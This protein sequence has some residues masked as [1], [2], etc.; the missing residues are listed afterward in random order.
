MVRNLDKEYK[1]VNTIYEQQKE[2]RTTPEGKIALRRAK[3]RQTLKQMRIIKKSHGGGLLPK[4][5][6]CT[7]KK[8]ERLVVNYDT[9]LCYNCKY[10]REEVLTEEEICQ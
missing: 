8:F 9:V 6:E 7:E 3:E 2:Y 1:G 5:A 10:E 4:C